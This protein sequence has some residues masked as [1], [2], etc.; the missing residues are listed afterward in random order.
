MTTIALNKMC[1][2]FALLGLSII[3]ISPQSHSPTDDNGFIRK[4]IN[5]SGVLLEMITPAEYLCVINSR[6]DNGAY[7]FLLRNGGENQLLGNG[8]SAFL[9]VFHLAPSPGGK[10]LAVSSVGEGHPIVEIVDAADL[11]E[12][13]KYRVLHQINPY[14]GSI[15][16]ER[17]EGD[18]VILGANVPL[19]RR[20][21][22]EP[23]SP[24]EMTEEFMLFSL[25]VPSGVIT[26][27]NRLIG[28]K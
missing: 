27:L 7:W 1:F 5:E 6:D 3:P 21:N 4:V 11:W 2:I 17:W 25:D 10:Y 16:V 12:N 19:Q 18:N 22:E 20:Q 14:P 28:E 26:P 23:V 8:L 15:S 9:Q 13:K 24:E